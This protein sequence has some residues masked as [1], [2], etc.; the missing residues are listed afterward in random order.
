M[1]ARQA[2]IYYDYLANVLDELSDAMGEIKE[3]LLD[4]PNVY[5][6]IKLIALT[7]LYKQLSCLTYDE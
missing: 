7:K 6:Q 1:N 5:L 2:A 3:E 4:H